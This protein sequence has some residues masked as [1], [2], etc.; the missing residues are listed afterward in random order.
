MPHTLF[1]VASLHLTMWAK[2][3]LLTQASTDGHLPFANI[4]LFVIGNCQEYKQTS[5][6]DQMSHSYW[7]QDLLLKSAS[8]RDWCWSLSSEVSVHLLWGGKGDGK[9]LF[10]S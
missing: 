3:T 10:T 9:C 8:F 6:K 4:A 2:Y 5:F 1:T 7:F